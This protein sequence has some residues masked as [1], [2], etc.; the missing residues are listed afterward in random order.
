MRQTISP[1]SNKRG[2]LKV[3]QHMRESPAKLSV[4]MC[5][6]N[7]AVYLPASASYLSMTLAG[8]RPRSLTSMPLLLAQSR[9]AWF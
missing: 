4:A 7:G 1:Q 9:M 2:A 5:T 3:T 6:F 8:I